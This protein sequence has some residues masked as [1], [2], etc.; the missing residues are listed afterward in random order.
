MASKKKQRNE[1]LEDHATQ[2]KKA[3]KNNFNTGGNASDYDGGQPA[4]TK[5]GNPGRIHSDEDG[6]SGNKDSSSEKEFNAGGGD[7]DYD[8]GHPEDVKKNSAGRI[9]SEEGE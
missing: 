3:E 4:D 5:T 8:G 2:K 1:H 7:S 9:H 6:H